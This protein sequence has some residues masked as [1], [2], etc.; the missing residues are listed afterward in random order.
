MGYKKAPGASG[1]LKRENDNAQGY[2]TIKRNHNSQQVEI[3]QIIFL[4][5]PYLLAEAR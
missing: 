3:R 5:K 2:R 1:N 4:V